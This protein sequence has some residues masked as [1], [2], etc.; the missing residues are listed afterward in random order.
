MKQRFL[1][2]S[3]LLLALAPVPALRAQTSFGKDTEALL[4]S[5]EDAIENKAAFADQREAGLSRLKADAR[6]TNGT[7]RIEYLK[8]LYESYLHVQADSAMLY[9]E[10]IASEPEAATNADL[11]NYV[12]ISKANIWA[13]RGQY[14]Q[15]MSELAVIN[16]AVFTVE[17]Q[18]YYFRTMRTLYGWMANYA[19]GT[20][21]EAD[22]L[23]RTQ[24]YRDSILL[25]PQSEN[26]RLVVL[27]DQAI[28]QGNADEALRLC[29]RSLRSEDDTRVYSYFIMA[30]AYRV[31]GD[32]EREVYYLAQTALHD[33]RSG[34][35]EYQAL[36][37]LAQR[38]YEA[39]HVRLSY[40]F[41]LCSIE[42]A[43]HCKAPL[44]SFEATNLLTIVDKT[45]NSQERR[46]KRLSYLFLLGLTALSLLLIFMVVWLRRQMKKLSQAR[47]EL[48]DANA[49]L[50]VVNDELLEANKS[51]QQ[52][53]S[54]LL[55]TD[56]MKEEYIARYLDR[57]RDYLDELD[58]Y[59]RTLLRL[60]KAGKYDALHKQLTSE[61][62]TA[63]EKK[64]FY[65]DFDHAF[66]NL[67]PHFVEKF[68]ALL[69]PEARVELRPA[70]SDPKQR[71][72][73]RERL[74]Q[75]LR[76]FALIRLGVSESSRMA[77][78]LGL[79]LTTVYNYRSRFRNKALCDK[80]DFEVRVMEI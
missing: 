58:H 8:R 44:R 4:D 34:V 15:A 55:L 31:R 41:L 60:S 53:H 39:G 25:M 68:N 11:R 32:T 64:R 33:I 12:C 13:L 27:A 9:V 47:H 43:T 2:F 50:Q 59:R 79:S 21:T 69:Q 57:C 14:H 74:T 66:L 48:A 56:K 80:D 18:L 46:Q 75:E 71:P 7:L 51:L 73:E 26:S 17:T 49:R 10:A 42:D 1:L 38:L 40:A 24:L 6:R 78:F 70:A 77:H 35:N 36:P 67:F 23:E 62:W 72:A 54:D 16:R 45:Y 30:E 28:W 52:V 3:L 29:E 5:L 37:R 63:A 19:E 65:A 20:S 22:L 76:L 61:A